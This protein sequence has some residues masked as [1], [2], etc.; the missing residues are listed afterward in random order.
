MSF[1]L[2]FHK[3]LASSGSK[4]STYWNY[5]AFI[6]S[7]SNFMPWKKLQCHF[8]LSFKSIFYFDFRSRMTGGGFGGC[9]VTLLKEEVLE[10]CVKFIT[11]S[12]SKK[13]TF[14]VCLPS[15]GAKIIKSWFF[16]LEL[17]N[18]PPNESLNWN[19]SLFT[20]RIYFSLTQSCKFKEMQMRISEEMKR[21]GKILATIH[22]T[23]RC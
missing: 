13:P 22:R 10:D 20:G 11:E 7:L 1:L 21:A 14:Y 18:V 23:L 9:T 2:K 15:D 12:Y 8:E 4:T 17:T 5:A 19:C 16:I 6:L 3:G